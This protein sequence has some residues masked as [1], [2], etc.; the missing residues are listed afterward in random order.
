MKIEVI[1]SELKKSFPLASSVAYGSIGYL[2]T[3][4]GHNNYEGQL[5]MKGYNEC[6]IK[7]EDGNTWSELASTHYRFEVLPKGT[8]IKITI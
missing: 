2:H 5:V 7:L 1:K 8:E 3:I 6:L 4:S